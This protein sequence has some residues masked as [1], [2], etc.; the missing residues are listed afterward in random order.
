[1][2]NHLDHL[3]KNHL[4]CRWKKVV[5]HTLPILATPLAQIVI[6]YA[7]F[8]VAVERLLCF[9]RTTKTEWVLPGRLLP[10]TRKTQNINRKNIYAYSY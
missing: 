6:V 7:L 5:K 8:A 2:K 9:A 4:D 3:L 10:G 1:M